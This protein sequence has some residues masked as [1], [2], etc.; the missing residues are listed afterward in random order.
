MLF[1]MLMEEARGMTDDALMEVIHFI[2]FLKVAPTMTASVSMA[3]KSSDEKII[4]R[5]P[6]LYKDQIQI[7]DGFDDPLDEFE[8][9]M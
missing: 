3:S 7:A 6:G 8:E 2:Q 4:Y 1:E 5:E 9:Y